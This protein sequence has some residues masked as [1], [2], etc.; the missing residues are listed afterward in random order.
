MPGGC[1]NAERHDGY[2]QPAEERLL[3]VVRAPPT[4][5]S[6]K[7]QRVHEPRT[8]YV[9]FKSQISDAGDARMVTELRKSDSGDDYHLWRFVTN[10]AHVLACVAANPS[11]RLRDI[12]QTI[13]ITERTVG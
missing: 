2:Q 10:H 13:G 9:Y 7:I 6:G 12:A 8:S 5:A 4:G 1:A 3:P 11:A